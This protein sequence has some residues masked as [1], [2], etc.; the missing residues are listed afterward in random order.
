MQS[1]DIKT[2]FMDTKLLSLGYSGN[3]NFPLSPLT[4]SS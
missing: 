4:N 3:E 2:H 1:K